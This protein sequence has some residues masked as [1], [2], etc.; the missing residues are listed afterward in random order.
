MPDSQEE[1]GA[2]PGHPPIAA[3]NGGFAE[4]R[5]DE[6]AQAY[7]LRSELAEYRIVL[8]PPEER[9]GLLRIEGR[10]PGEEWQPLVRAAGMLLREGDGT[11][12]PPD[13]SAARCERVRMEA[14][15]DERSLVLRFEQSDGRRSMLHSLRLERVG[16]ALRGRV[17]APAGRGGEGWCGFALGPV[18][19]EAA[20]RVEVPG[21]PEPL[22]VMPGGGFL[23]A[24]VDR[25]TGNATSYPPAGALYRPDVRGGM[26]PIEE[27]FYVT[28]SPDP[29]DPLP[30]L[31]AEPAAH[32]AALTRRIT[33][34]HYSEDA[35]A[36]DRRFFD[37]L[38]AYGLDDLLVIYRNW[39]QHGYRR[40]E[41]G[42]YPA[43]SRRG[44]VEEFRGV[45]ES[46]AARGWLVALRQEFAAIDRESGYWSESVA[47]L[48]EDGTTRP[49]RQPGS[50]AIAA[51]AMG[52][53][54]R[55]EATQIAR[56][57]RT[58]AVFVDAH[59]AVTP[60]GGLR[61]VD[62]RPSSRASTEGR[63][64]SEVENL[65]AALRDLYRGPVIGASGEGPWRLD[66]FMAG[67]VEG[68][69]R[70]LEPARSPAPPVDYELRQ[71]R[72][73]LVGIGAGTYGQFTGVGEEAIDSQRLDRDA[74]RAAEIAAGHAG[75]FANYLLRTD[76]HGPPFPAG[77][78]AECV[79]EYFLIRALQ[80]AYLDA[81]VAAIRY[82]SDGEMLD[83]AAALRRGADLAQV[84]IEYGNGLTVWVNRSYR[85]AWEVEAAGA[86]YR[87][88]SSGF[89]AAAP[90]QG[91]LAYTAE[92]GSQRTD[93]CASPRYTFVDVRGGRSRA[94]EGITT[95]GAAALLRGD[96]ARSPDVVMVGARQ[97]RVGD[98][99]DYLLS[100]RGDIRLRRLSDLEVE[101]TVL[102]TE[103]GKPV[104]VTWPA[105]AVLW[106]EAPIVV[107]EIERGRSYP[108]R[109]QVSM[110]RG[111]PQ[112]ARACPGVTYRVRAGA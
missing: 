41:P 51:D 93:F 35:Y 103:N 58:P 77:S 90:G 106:R 37:L 1:R 28:L 80:E 69:V 57:Y 89:L 85:E 48:G 102:G 8:G 56:N 40:R 73:A 24:Y 66:T 50:C 76:P 67:T 75:Y 11:V 32:R 10:L 63:A 99:D 49:A 97:L 109:C 6:A 110:T 68:V 27:T 60:E 5:W 23:G 65:L 91:L 112:L 100:E 20:R 46:A 2:A 62:A 98:D 25:F 4:P 84:R 45:L 92:V 16:G 14:Q 42:L 78:A 96:F 101:L 104:H 9:T 17:E 53:L 30:S 33:F 22:V 31:R 39:Q 19:P 64:L 21:L 3:H 7:Q 88:P 107:T 79:R 34:D 72:P 29:L 61:Q 38:A 108:S 12:Q 36:E 18:G 13:A 87:L 111:G 47:A 59:T 70:A 55:L 105:P 26:L 95:D 82:R 54:A 83:L 71:V 81:P 94:V 86:T 15:A 74:Y 52:E 43:S 44:R